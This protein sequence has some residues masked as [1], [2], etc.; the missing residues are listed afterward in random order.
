MFGTSQSIKICNFTGYKTVANCSGHTYTT[1]SPAS[2]GT[3]GKCNT[4]NYER[5]RVTVNTFAPF[6]TNTTKNI[7][8]SASINCYRMSASVTTPDSTVTWLGDVMNTSTYSKSYTFSTAGIYTVT[9]YARDINDSLS[10]S[11]SKGT[12]YQIRVQ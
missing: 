6:A 5:L 11:F 7:T 2:D 12:T 4:C 1:I 3:D 8:G 9:L 10:G